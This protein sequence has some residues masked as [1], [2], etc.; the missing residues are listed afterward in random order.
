MKRLWVQVA[1]ATLALSMLQAALSFIVPPSPAAPPALVPVLLSNLLIAVLLTWTAA[2]LRAQG[3]W[4]PLIL[5]AIWGGVQANSMLETLLFDVGM[6][7]ADV[8]RVTAWLLAVSG[9]FAIVVGLLFRSAPIEPSSARAI[10]WPPA[11][12]FGLCALAYVALYFTAGTL[13]WPFIREFYEARPMP[14]Q[15]TVIG[16]Q[17]VRG[18]GYAVIVWVLMSKLRASRAAA[19]WVCGLTLSVLGGIAPLLIPNPYLP[20]HVRHAHLI[21]TSVSNFLFGWLA[22][23][24]LSG[25]RRKQALREA[26]PARANVR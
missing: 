10:R 11:W 4:R 3:V 25:A 23:W 16:L 26:A 7:P 22:G 19:A 18:L 12:R 17:V 1:I 24:L 2:R 21:E 15:V 5:W 8:A 9:C 14:P 13:V 20:D 6:P